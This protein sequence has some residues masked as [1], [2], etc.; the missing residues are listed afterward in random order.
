MID[1]AWE[2]TGAVRAVHVHGDRACTLAS[3]PRW[4]HWDGRSGTEG[5][6]GTLWLL[7]DTGHAQGTVVRD[8]SVVERPLAR[9]SE[10]VVDARFLP[11]KSLQ[12]ALSLIQ[13]SSGMARVVLA[14]LGDSTATMD[15]LK[16]RMNAPEMVASIDGSTLLLSSPWTEGVYSR[17]ATDGASGDDVNV[18]PAFEEGAFDW[19]LLDRSRYWVARREGLVERSLDDREKLAWIVRFE[20]TATECVLAANAGSAVLGLFS[21]DERGARVRFVRGDGTLWFEQ[22]FDWSSSFYVAVDEGVLTADRAGQRWLLAPSGE[23]TAIDVRG[24]MFAATSDHWITSTSGELALIARSAGASTVRPE[25]RPV[26]SLALSADGAR[27][28]CCEG[29][30]R[31]RSYRARDGAIEA[32]LVL[33]A[34]T[35]HWV[36]RL[37]EGGRSAAIVRRDE[38]DRA[39]SLWRIDATEAALDEAFDIEGE[40]VSLLAVSSDGSRTI[41]DHGDGELVLRSRRSDEP[42]EKSVRFEGGDESAQRLLARFTEDGL[43]ELLSDTRV[44]RYEL[45]RWTVVTDEPR[46]AQ[47]RPGLAAMGKLR[48]EERARPGSVPALEVRSERGSVRWADSTLLR[49]AVVALACADDVERV[50]VALTPSMLFIV[51]DGEGRE[52]ARV[53]RKQSTADRVTAL[54]LSDDGRTLVAGTQSGQRI[55][56]ELD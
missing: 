30:Q 33:G 12:I 10:T 37:C 49:R 47:E 53:S 52:L 41:E 21:R 44:T 15:L 7:S 1:E 26:T 20:R 3:A 9:A 23:R 13:P 34:G 55:V 43:V 38:G 28:V 31:L 4:W 19:A 17:R 56:V 46:A 29:G 14:D 35:A 32:E 45:D 48:V 40:R 16:P 27:V 50:A 42:Q 18:E 39:V 11:G 54:A 24:A 25:A 36:A 51:L 8:F 2:A 6:E 5:T 22:D